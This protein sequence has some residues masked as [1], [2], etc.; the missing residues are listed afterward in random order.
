LVKQRID[1]TAHVD[2]RIRLPDTL[3]IGANVQIYGS[4]LL[5]DGLRIEPNVVIYGPAEIGSGSYVGPNSIIG[6][7]SRAQL[8]DRLLNG[9]N[10]Y[11]KHKPVRIGLKAIIRSNCVLYSNVTVGDKVRFGHNI[12]IREKVSVGDNSL[13]GTNVVIDGS[14]RIGRNVSIQTG[15]YISTFS[16]IEDRVFLGPRSILINDRYAM[17]KA[18]VLVGPTVRQGASIGANATIFPGITVGEGA[19]V[20]AGAVVIDDVAPKSIVVGI[21][22]EKVK[23]VPQDWRIQLT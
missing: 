13:I 20:G 3:F 15:A 14:C 8:R 6:F 4:V 12:M 18:C 7:P 9:T 1:K 5:G 22:A 11:L 16:T 2:E 21:P 19:V 23:N 10:E 17:Q